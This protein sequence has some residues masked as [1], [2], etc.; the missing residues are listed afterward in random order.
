MVLDV[1]SEFPLQVT[2]GAAA[3]WLMLYI[4]VSAGADWINILP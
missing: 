2:E 4:S 1:Y 3:D